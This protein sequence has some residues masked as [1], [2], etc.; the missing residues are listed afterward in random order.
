M[1]FIISL[2]LIVSSEWVGN[3]TLSPSM[4]TYNPI[5]IAVRYLKW[6]IDL[7]LPICQLTNLT[8]NC[9][10]KAMI[11]SE[12]TNIIETLESSNPLIAIVIRNNHH[13]INSTV[14]IFEISEKHAEGLLNITDSSMH[15]LFDYNCNP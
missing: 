10:D 5:R 15:I 4:K 12:T 9:T 6:P 1:L 3:F 13:P 8:A 2:F 14:P 7:N 11:I